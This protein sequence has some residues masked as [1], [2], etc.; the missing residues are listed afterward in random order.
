MG[1][2]T[3][4]IIDINDCRVTFVT[5][6][7]FEY[8]LF[9]RQRKKVYFSIKKISI[10]NVNK[11]CEKVFEKDKLNCFL[12]DFT[13]EPLPTGACCRISCSNFAGEGMNPISQFSLTL[14]PIHQLASYF[15]NMCRKSPILK[16]KMGNNQ[17]RFCQTDEYQVG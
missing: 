12:K 13:L 4:Y 2:Q 11:G 5:I 10:S 16:L 8:F 6:N 7:C 17:N 3:N 9:V 15:S 1:R 14:R